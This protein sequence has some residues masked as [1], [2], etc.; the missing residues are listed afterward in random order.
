ML[1]SDFIKLSGK[2]QRVVLPSFILRITT[3]SAIQPRIHEVHLTSPS[4]SERGK[5]RFTPL[6][7][8]HKQ[9]LSTQIYLC[10]SLD[11]VYCCFSSTSG[12]IYQRRRYA[13]SVGFPR[14]T[15]IYVLSITVD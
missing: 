1:I 13:L 6:P 4:Y 9:T 3:S 7:D 15:Y 5:G 14:E 11:V 2:P 8:R 10:G 12:V